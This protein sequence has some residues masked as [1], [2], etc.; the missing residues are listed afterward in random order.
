MWQAIIPLIGSLIDKA[1]PDAD[2]ANK[3]KAELAMMQAKGELDLMLGQIEINKAE[4]QHSSVFVSGWR[5]AVGWICAAALGYEFIAMPL[6]AWASLNFG[7]QS[8]PHL[9]MDGLMELVLAMLG[10]AGLRT[11]EKYKGVAR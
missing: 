6:F 4:A 8:P 5:P 9:V 11:F 7:W 2:A 1:I 3:A 10:V